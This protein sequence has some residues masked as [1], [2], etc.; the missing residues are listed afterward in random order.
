MGWAESAGV[1]TGYGNAE[2]FGGTALITR[3]QLMLMTS[4]YMDYECIG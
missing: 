3:E 2:T 4:R 1:I